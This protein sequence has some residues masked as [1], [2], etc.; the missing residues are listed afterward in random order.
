MYR[1]G[2]AAKRR[3]R[4]FQILLGA[5]AAV[6]I[7]A[8]VMVA[9]TSGAGAGKSSGCA[10]LDVSESTEDARASY[11][12]KFAE[13]ATEIGNDGSGNVCVILAAADPLAEAVPVS[14]SVAPDPKNVGT[15]DA[16]IE[17]EEKVEAMT[18]GVADLLEDPGIDDRG[19][20]LVE[21]ANVAA[22]HLQA[23]DRL[24]YLSDGL[25]WSKSVGHLMQMDLSTA[26][27]A[28]LIR[29][30]DREGMLPDL[31][32]VQVDFPLM[33]FHPEGFTG[34]LAQENR[35]PVF[36]EAWAAATH[37]NLTIETPQ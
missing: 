5:G 33:L 28:A 32:G 34:D 21:A 30:L 23:G 19:S 16:P 12:E 13:F 1:S 22:K 25:Q 26:G 10:I 4:Q 29:R 31:R 3:R 27:I 35:V 2:A 15:P 14:N 9:L 8:V 17:I 6:A 37:A 18:A 24:V 7:L 20:G 36:W 11:T